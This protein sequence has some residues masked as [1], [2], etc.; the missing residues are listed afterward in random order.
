LLPGR[1]AGRHGGLVQGNDF[2]VHGSVAAG[3]CIVATQRQAYRAG[4]FSR[5]PPKLSYII[6]NNARFM[7]YFRQQ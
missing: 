1:I 2:L 4:L 3:I 6:E 7:A 5:H